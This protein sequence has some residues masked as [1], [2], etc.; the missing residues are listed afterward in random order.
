MDFT[1]TKKKDSIKKNSRIELSARFYQFVFVLSIS[2]GNAT[3]INNN[4]ESSL[5]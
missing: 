2:K 3:L 1:K 5:I 4:L